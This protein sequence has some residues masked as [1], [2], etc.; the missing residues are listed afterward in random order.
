MRLDELY[1]CVN[2]HIIFEVIKGQ[3]HKYQHL[4]KKY[5]YK[6][7]P[8]SIDE[9]T[10]KE[11]ENINLT[12][13]YQSKILEFIK[14]SLQDND[15]IIYGQMNEI[16]KKE[17]INNSLYMTDTYVFDMDNYYY[18]FNWKSNDQC[19]NAILC[20]KNFFNSTHSR[21]LTKISDAGWKLNYFMS[22]D[23]IYNSND[24]KIDMEWIKL[25]VK[26]GM[27]ITDKTQNKSTKIT[28]NINADDLPSIYN[29]I[30]KEYQIN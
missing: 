25:C 15:I 17:I 11:N 1:D 29:K 5:E 23:D 22:V 13:Y 30:K 24:K 6:I 26:Y 7:I 21:E 14:V 28:K 27:N 3:Y 10:S 4:L 18:N 9:P 20:R 19:I 12:A 8:I 16:P 2:V